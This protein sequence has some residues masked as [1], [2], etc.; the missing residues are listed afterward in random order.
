MNIKDKNHYEKTLELYKNGIWFDYSDVHNDVDIMYEKIE[1][2]SKEKKIFI[3]LGRG[4][5]L[6][7]RILLQHYEDNK[8]D[9]KIYS[10]RTQYQKLGTK[11]EKPIVIETLS[12]ESIKEIN[13]LLVQNYE[14]WILDGPLVMGKTISCARQY[15]DKIFN[16]N[17]HV[18]VLHQILFNNDPTAQWRKQSPVVPDIVARSYTFQNLKY[19]NYPWEWKNYTLYKL[20]ANAYK[21][22]VDE[23]SLYYILKNYY[24]QTNNFSK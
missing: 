8:I 6:I 10:I 24:E 21:K 23:S 9:V 7:S 12:E 11:E 17:C 15:L 13:E 3:V 14:I 1:N 19:I 18:A 2:T 4:A 16:K 22:G 5:W 20:L